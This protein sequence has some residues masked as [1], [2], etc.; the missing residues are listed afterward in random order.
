MKVGIFLSSQWQPETELGPALDDLR[1]QV[2]VAKDNGF[3]SIWVG[4]H[5]VTAP[6]QMAQPVPLLARL[7]ADAEGMT[8]GTSIMLL[9]MLNPV[10]VA[11]DIATLDWL[12]DGNFILGAGMG[13]RPEEFEALGAPI[14][15]RVG[16]MREFVTLLRQLWTEDT[17]SFEGRY[18]K[19][20]GVGA[21]IKPK[22]DGGPPI[23]LAGEVIPAVKRAA[24]IA[25]A[26]FP[27]PVPT[28]Q[29]I[30]ELYDVYKAERAET[31]L[32]LP[33]EMP[34]IRECYVGET[35]ESAMA[36]A[37]GP[38]QVK[39]KSYAAWGQ[40]ESAATSNRLQADFPGF[41]KDRFLIGDEAQVRDELERYRDE[42]GIDHFCMRMQWYGLEQDLV[43]NSM[44]RLGRIAASIR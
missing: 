37:S 14:N 33:D 34:I 19:L 23:W 25:D 15:E 38:L 29:S 3:S 7:A 6:L 16:R 40:E 36:E 32:P 42:V 9:S 41:A 28:M 43:L 22:Q 18:F 8:L 44:E 1:R 35:P 39:Y 31:G 17:V 2:A 5:Y 13:Y 30:G 21:S 12:C 11:E 24:Q 26:W 27:L 10:Q 4:Q 20:D